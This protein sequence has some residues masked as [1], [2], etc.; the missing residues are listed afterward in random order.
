MSKMRGIIEILIITLIFIIG[1]YLFY[2]IVGL[3]NIIYILI[4]FPLWLLLGWYLTK[5]KEKNKLD[6]G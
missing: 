5:K 1:G 2:Q 4:I 6:E 3:T